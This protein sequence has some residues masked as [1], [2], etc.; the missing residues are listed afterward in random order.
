[1]KKI[2]FILE[3]LGE[4]GGGAERFIINLCNELSKKNP[5]IYILSL[6]DKGNFYKKYINKRVN[7]IVFPFKKSF[8]SLAHLFN[9]L[10]KNKPYIVFSTSFHV[11]VYSIILKILIKKKFYLVSR[12][13]NNINQYFSKY[14]SFK[15]NIINYL[16][17]NNLKYIDNFVCP[18]KGLVDELRKHVDKKDYKKIFLINNSIDEK[19]ILRQSKLKSSKNTFIKKNFFLNIGRLVPNKDHRTLIKAFNYFLTLKT[20]KNK[21]YFLVI[22][23]VGNLLKDI[24]SYIKE[25]NLQKKVI[26]LKNINNPYIFIKKSKIFILSSKFEGYPNVL[27]EAQALNKKIISTDCKHGPREILDNGKYGY[28]VKTGDYKSLGLTMD[29]ALI[30]KNNSISLIKLK[31]RN[32]LKLIALKYYN[33]FENLNEK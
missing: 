31:K 32:S 30:N 22:I 11:T 27:L 1:M 13:S 12:I 28:L 25:L 26:I 29:K 21:D 19:Y 8:H 4:S 5:Y 24:K 33:L 9:F 23:G 6:T 3:N 16:Y 20:R 14:K 17:F 7:L 2:F 18:S 10:I 15:L